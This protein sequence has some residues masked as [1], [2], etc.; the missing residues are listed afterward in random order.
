MVLVLQRTGEMARAESRKEFSEIADLGVAANRL[1]EQLENFSKW[2]AVTG[3]LLLPSYIGSIPFPISGLARNSKA[4]PADMLV[5][6]DGCT[7]TR[8]CCVSCARS[9]TVTA[10]PHPGQFARTPALSSPVLSSFWQCG[11]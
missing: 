8:S 5:A 3:A 4:V 9:G 10:C 2:A 1:S 11:Q 6:S 7:R